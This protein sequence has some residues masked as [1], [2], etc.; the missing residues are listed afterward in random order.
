M[1]K[2]KS[3]FAMIL[4]VKLPNNIST[5]TLTNKLKS[6]INKLHLYVSLRELKAS[7]IR[8]EKPV[9]EPYIISVFGSDK[10]GIVYNI[11]EILAKNKVNITDVQTDIS[12]GTYIM[13]IEVRIPD[14]ININTLKN[15]L[16]TIA[17]S[18][19]VS[20]SINPVETPEL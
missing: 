7:E 5:N 4:I 6:R 16:E 15:Q 2:L 14:I 10:P 20:V 1:T 12:D 18:L 19:N 11:S 17:K 3:E 8:K 13:L 9:G